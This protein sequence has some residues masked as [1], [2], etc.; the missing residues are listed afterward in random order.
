[1]SGPI[2]D[3]LKPTLQGYLRG[4]SDP[5]K[6]IEKL[7][8]FKDKM[9]SNEY[10]YNLTN[11]QLRYVNGLIDQELARRQVGSVVD[12]N[13]TRW[14]VTSAGGDSVYVDAD[15]PRQAKV[16]A[17]ELFAREHGLNVDA[18]DLVAIAATQGSG[19]VHA[20][21]QQWR[22][23]VDTLPNRRTEVIADF[24]RQIEQGEHNPSLESQQQRDAVIRAIDDELRRRQD[25]GETGE[26][27]S[28]IV[29]DGF[30]RPVGTVQA[31]TRDEA[32][33]IYGSTNDVDTRNYTATPGAGNTT[34]NTDGMSTTSREVFDSLPEGTRSW[35]ERVGEHHNLELR[36]ALD[37]IEAGRGIGSGL[38]SNQVAFVK[39]AI[40]TELRRRSNNDSVDS[41][42]TT[43][44]PVFDT[45][46]QH[47][48]DFIANDLSYSA[49]MHL[50]NMLRNLSRDDAGSQV[51]LNDQ[52][53]AYIRILIKR[54]LRANGI[55]PDD[56]APA[57]QPTTTYA[58]DANE[59]ERMRREREQISQDMA[60][61]TNESINLLRKLAGLK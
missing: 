32:L 12:N 47:W 3:S 58:D 44:N 42:D 16:K 56:D 55:N 24:R 20:I 53:L 19:A 14:R 8:A 41:D 22:N 30:N 5:F 29:L 40:E 34:S 43:R 31:R 25:Q 4:L 52:Q 37:H 23:W 10:D 57:E 33:R 2:W 27:Q 6:T 60:Q 28:W 39:T 13:S 50:I 36:Q 17:V 35:L 48:K 18:N 38:Y 54:Q 21:P 9:A 7:H 51:N 46:P 59:R 61:S 15:S 45:L 1:M 26:E 11:E 49:D